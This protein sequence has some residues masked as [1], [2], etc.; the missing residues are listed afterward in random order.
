MLHAFNI[1]EQKEKSEERQGSVLKEN[2]SKMM[3]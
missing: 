2:I 1:G 3:C